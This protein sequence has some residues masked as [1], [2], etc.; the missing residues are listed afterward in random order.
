MTPTENR[1]EHDI[2]VRLTMGRTVNRPWLEGRAIAI[3]EALESRCP[4]VLGPSV[5]AN[6]KENGWDLDLTILASGVADAYDKLGQ[7]FA[8]VETVAEI[9]F[10]GDGPDEVRASGLASTQPRGDHSGVLAPA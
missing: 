4:D 3:E 2:L 7:V 8:T 10:V 5:T 6:F 9:E 1:T